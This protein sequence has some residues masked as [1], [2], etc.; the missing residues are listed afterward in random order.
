[1]SA[2]TKA[3]ADTVVSPS[4]M[5]NAVSVGPDTM[6]TPAGNKEAETSLP[7]APGRLG[8]SRTVVKKQQIFYPSLRRRKFIGFASAISRTLGKKVSGA[9]KRI[10]GVKVH[11]KKICFMVGSFI[12]ILITLQ[13]YQNYREGGRFMTTTRLSIMDKE[14]Q[15]TCRYI[16]AHYDDPALDLQTICSALVTGGAFLE[17]LFIKELGLTVDDFIVQVRINRAK[18]ALR[19]NPELPLDVLAR[20]VGYDDREAFI[21]RFEAVTGIGCQSYREALAQGDNA[22]A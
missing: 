7:V 17:A 22:A 18:I 21:R 3:S 16:E 15:R 10:A 9:Y 4:G 1:L 2:L 5:L 8:L 13:F 12:L 14:V 11:L 20:S 19:K 6:L